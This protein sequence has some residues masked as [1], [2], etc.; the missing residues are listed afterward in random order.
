MDFVAASRVMD[1]YMIQESFVD[2][3]GKVKG[4]WIKRMKRWEAVQGL[5]IESLNLGR[6]KVV[7]VE[8]WRG[9]G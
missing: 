4:L 7:V 1:V 6:E 5:W 3:C 8:K 9:C 2:G